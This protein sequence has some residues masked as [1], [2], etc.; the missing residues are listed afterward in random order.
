MKVVKFFIAFLAI[1]I[2][3]SFGSTTKP[4]LDAAPLKS[5]AA[6]TEITPEAT[7]TT[8]SI[9]SSY[10][11]TRAV[12]RTNNNYISVAGKTISIQNSDNTNIDAGN[13]VK[14]YLDGKLGNKLYYGH[15]SSAV[16]GN[17]KNLVNGDTFSVTENG[18]TKTYRVAKTVTLTY[19]ETDR[20][21]PALPNASYNGNTYDIVLMTCAGT[22]YGDGNA[23]HRLL[24]F[25]VAV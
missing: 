24:I 16:F 14:H 9:A 8:A 22:S 21:M 2:D 19:A 7:Q 10:S 3:F 1:F 5:G 11:A 23:S 20:R 6:V 17:L 25:A 13:V 4:I 15:N 12:V 18:I